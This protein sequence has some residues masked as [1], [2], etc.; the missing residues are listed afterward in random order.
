MSGLVADWH[1]IGRPLA[2]WQIQLFYSKG[3]TL[4]NEHYCNR[5]FLQ[6]TTELQEKKNCQLKIQMCPTWSHSCCHL[7]K[8]N[9]IRMP[10]IHMS[11]VLRLVICIHCRTQCC[12][13]QHTTVHHC[14]VLYITAHH[15]TRHTTVQCCTP[16][17]S[18][19]SH[20]APLDTVVLHRAPCNLRCPYVCLY[21]PKSKF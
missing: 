11:P 6:T 4:R 20:P 18:A 12:I 1:R 2:G 16:L 21:V 7:N 19:A 3:C 9:N 17:P 13:S 14:T 15:C 10:N 8:N 5:Q